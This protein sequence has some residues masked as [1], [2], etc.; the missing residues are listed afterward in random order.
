MAN[1]VQCRY[2]RY[3]NNEPTL[4]Q[5]NTITLQVPGYVSLIKYS[6]PLTF[7]NNF[8]FNVPLMYFLS[9]YDTF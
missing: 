8:P 4:E 3:K 7:P 1:S 6:K 2:S 9:E 5:T